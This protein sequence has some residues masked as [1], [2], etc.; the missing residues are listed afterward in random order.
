MA[1]SKKSDYSP[2]VPQDITGLRSGSASPID[3]LLMLRTSPPTERA[4]A[5]RNRAVV[6]DAA[7]ALFRQHGVD[8]VSMDAIAAAAGVGKGTL[9]R[10]FGDKAGLAVALLDEQERTLQESILFGS[11]PLGPGKPDDDPTPRERLRAFV[12]AYLD[13]LLAHLPL[14]RMSETASPG[15][16]YRIGAYRFWHRHVSLLLSGRAD[17]Q[18]DAHTLLAA[19]AAEHVHA[20][21]AE[22]GHTRVRRAIL[23]LVDALTA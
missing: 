4:D 12:A 23:D 11:A 2:V 10:R 15:A 1:A 13:Y 21:A 5:A 6:L 16:R 14:V 7:A 9:F 18:A 8:A 17:P 20:V 3:E 22:L 19:L